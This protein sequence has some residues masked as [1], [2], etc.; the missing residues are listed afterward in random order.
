M[1]QPDSGLQKTDFLT[2]YT[3]IKALHP[4]N[5]SPFSSDS[6][7]FYK[8]NLGGLYPEKLAKENSNRAIANSET[9]KGRFC[10]ESWD[11]SRA[12]SHGNLS[13]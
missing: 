3:I 5:G 10:K 9:S 2:P 11:R 8:I 7:P 4:R 12:L 6:N 1:E 13:L